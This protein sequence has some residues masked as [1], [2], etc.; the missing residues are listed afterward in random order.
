MP[1]SFV[2]SD[3]LLDP[4]WDAFL[5]RTGGHHTQSS[6]WAKLKAGTGWR[7]LRLT[8][9]RD[10]IV[11]G[12]QLLVKSSHGISLAYVTRGPAL[13]ENGSLVGRLLEEFQSFARAE[14]LKIVLAQPPVLPHSL[15]SEMTRLGFR[16]S[17]VYAGPQ[18]TTIV[19]LTGSEDEILARMKQKTRY[20]IRLAGRKDVRV[21]EGSHDDIGTLHRLLTATATRQG[22]AEYP[23][24]YFERMAQIFGLGDGAQIFIA[25]V[26]GEPV[27]ANLGIRFGDT[28]CFKKGGWSGTHGNLHTNEAMHW[29]T[30][31]WARENGCTYYD[32]EGI[33]PG[34]AD[35]VLAGEPL[36]PDIHRL[37]R[38]KLGFGGDVLRLPGT[39]DW[40]NGL[41]ARGVR[42]IGT[43]F[44][45]RPWLRRVTA[46]VR[47]TRARG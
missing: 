43:E 24:A 44:A 3:K 25:E 9:Q 36:P 20:N 13:V 14:R 2:H 38:F 4:A 18:A 31:L 30:M 10:E 19:D 23:I 26:E 32:M 28:L 16:P 7:A 12:M 27:S 33:D 40:A 42:R 37:T 6:R 15:G 17:R 45:E 34:V 29:A 22:F 5:E 1:V 47:G 21:R 8:A 46:Q 11:G 39:Y 35:L 41:L